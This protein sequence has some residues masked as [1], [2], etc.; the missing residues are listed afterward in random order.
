MP[1]IRHL[2]RLRRSLGCPLGITTGA[3]TTD[4]LDTR[5][6]LE[7]SG[8][9]LCGTV[10]QKVYH[11]ASFQIDQNR[12]IAMSSTPS[13]I[14]NAQHTRDPTIADDELAHATQ[15]RIRTRR[16]PQ[17]PGYAPPRFCARHKPNVAEGFTQSQAT[18][19][20]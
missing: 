11:R 10:W 16:H 7:P 8:K 20:V 15:Q 13:P 19:S 17:S 12:A 1:A 2:Y 3:V 9:T 5:V 4:D 6:S 18:S 14:V